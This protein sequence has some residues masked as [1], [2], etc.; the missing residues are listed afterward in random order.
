M[1]YPIKSRGD[2]EKLEELDSLKNQVEELR[3]QDQ[4]GKQNF[5]E[6]M[7]KLIEPLTK[8]IEDTSE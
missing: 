7:K 1:F 5:H 3:V 6:D 8:T 2:L 4:I